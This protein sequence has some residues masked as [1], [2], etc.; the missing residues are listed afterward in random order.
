MSDTTLGDLTNSLDAQNQ[1]QKNASSSHHKN[2]NAQH[3]ARIKNSM[4]REAPNKGQGQGRGNQEKENA[5]VALEHA[6]NKQR[7]NN[8][9]NLLE[10]LLSMDNENQQ[11]SNKSGV[12]T[13]RHNRVS[14]DEEDDSPEE[15]EDEEDD[16]EY[17]M[18]KLKALLGSSS[19]KKKQV[20][21]NFQ[22]GNVLR[23]SSSYNEQD[24]N[25]N[26]FIYILDKMKRDLFYRLDIEEPNE[27]D[28]EDYDKVS[29]I[30]YEGREGQDYTV[31]VLLKFFEILKEKAKQF[32]DRYD[33]LEDNS[34]EA[35]A[36]QNK[37]EENKE[38]Q[39]EE[40]DKEKIRKKLGAQKNI[41]SK[42]DSNSSKEGLKLL[43]NSTKQPKAPEPQDIKDIISVDSP[44]LNY[45]NVHPSK[46]LGSI[47]MIT[48]KSSQ[49]QTI[50]IF[51][52]SNTEIYDKVEVIKNKEFD[53]LE[54]LTN[55]EIELNEKELEHCI[56]E[57]MKT[58]ALEV[59]KRFVPNSELKHDCWFIE[60]PKTKELA[61]KITLKL[62]PKCEQDFIIV[63][64]T[65]KPKYK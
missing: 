19:Q 3:Q 4:R 7:E 65:L 12:L 55:Y 59:K 56:T 38:D 35:N 42:P 46:L 8:E 57:E 58:K 61:K 9:K 54:E 18:S 63:L 29:K 47:I 13:E 15:N 36:H 30:F 28:A 49:D 22:K 24:G 11:N 17:A 48:N 14:Y 43:L 10:A 39:E 50:E 21:Q 31:S 40:S 52:D 20:Q 33:T 44:V 32:V 2:E 25:N 37:Q 27:D 64:K 1:R 16:K 34:S 45:G 6:K 41:T 5:N 53:Y 60:N 23:K 62:G 26:D 51:I